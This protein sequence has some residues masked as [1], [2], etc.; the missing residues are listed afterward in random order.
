MKKPKK[1]LLNINKNPFQ[2]KYKLS[3]AYICYK[4]YCFQNSFK[5]V[6]KKD[7]LGIPFITQIYFTNKNQNDSQID[8]TSLKIKNS[9]NNAVPF[10][11]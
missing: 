7:I 9:R 4:E 11:L 10:N 1:Q 6:K 5:H 8:N 2:S 3:K